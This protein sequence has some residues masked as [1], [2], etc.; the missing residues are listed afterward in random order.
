MFEYPSASPTLPA[1]AA[2]RPVSLPLPAFDNAALPLEALLDGG[3]C[4]VGLLYTGAAVAACGEI[5]ESQRPSTCPVLNL[6][7]CADF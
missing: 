4:C 5:L 2:T 3:D 1:P 7:V 6:Y